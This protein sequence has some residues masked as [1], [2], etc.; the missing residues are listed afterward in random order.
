MAFSRRLSPDS[1][2][3]VLTSGHPEHDSTHASEI[4]LRTVT[5]RGT[6]RLPGLEAFGSR[7][8][9]IDRNAAGSRRRAEAFELEALDPMVKRGSIFD[10]DVTCEVGTER[11]VGAALL[12]TVTWR[13]AGQQSPFTLTFPI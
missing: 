3:Y 4:V 6:M 8:R 5:Q 11:G 13:E 9:T 10:L 1:F 12:L 7:L 2:D